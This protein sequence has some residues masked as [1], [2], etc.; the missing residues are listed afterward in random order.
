[1]RTPK[2]NLNAFN[3]RDFGMLQKTIP[4]APKKN[5]ALVAHDNRKDELLE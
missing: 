1:M 3:L 4:I 2:I 5:I